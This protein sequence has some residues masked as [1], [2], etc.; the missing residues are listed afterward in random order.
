MDRTRWLAA[1]ELA[2]AVFLTAPAAEVACV[3]TPGRNAPGA[4]VAEPS[5]RIAQFAGLTGQLCRILKEMAD[6]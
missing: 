3:M 5:K 6:E 4:S 2:R 1:G